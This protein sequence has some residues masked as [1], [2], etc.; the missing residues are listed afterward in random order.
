MGAAGTRAGDLLPG[1]PRIRTSDLLRAFILGQP[2][3]LPAVSPVD[4]AMACGHG[5]AYLP[6]AS[7]EGFF[8]E[9]H[10][11][12]R[13]GG[14][15][16]CDLINAESLSSTEGVRIADGGDAQGDDVALFGE[17]VD[18][19]QSRLLR[20][21]VVLDRR[22]QRPLARQ[23]IALQAYRAHEVRQ[24]LSGIG[25]GRVRVADACGDAFD[26]AARTCVLIAERGR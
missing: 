4:V 5:L 22:Q 20:L 26:P 8:R 11:A 10:R 14:I 6:P 16:V 13:P 21:C 25:F 19:E 2:A 1:A 24:L 23:T 12:L 9:V 17:H 15:F 18:Q 7:L 3:S